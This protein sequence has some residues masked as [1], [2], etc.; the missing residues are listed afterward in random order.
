MGP[1]EEAHGHISDPSR[2]HKGQEVLDSEKSKH[3]IRLLCGKKEAESCKEKD[4][5]IYP[6]LACGKSIRLSFWEMWYNIIF[7]FY[8]KMKCTNS[9]GGTDQT[10][11]VGDIK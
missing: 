8:L 4:N 6:S 9:L 10:S 11:Y 1:W 3:R 5:Y 7:L 2:F